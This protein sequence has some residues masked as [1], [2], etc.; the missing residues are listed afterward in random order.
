MGIGRDIPVPARDIARARCIPVEAIEAWL[1][2]AEAGSRIVYYSGYGPPPMDVANA[3]LRRLCDEG[4]VTFCQTRRTVGEGWD[5][6]A[7]RCGEPVPLAVG[8]G[9]NDAR[10]RRTASRGY[11]DPR[12]G[13]GGVMAVLLRH[14]RFGLP[15]PPN[16]EIAKLAGLT[17]RHQAAHHIR[18]LREDGAIVVKTEEMDGRGFVR[19]IGVFDPDR[20]K[21]RWTR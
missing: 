14:A 10:F 19:R 5:Y 9:T 16:G 2:L 6:C 12:D 20:D 13:R 21:W 3:L 11:T 17:T 1:E 4:E 18:R 7:V 8:F 15:C